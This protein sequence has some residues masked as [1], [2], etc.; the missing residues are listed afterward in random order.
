MSKWI[1]ETFEVE[2]PDYPYSTKFDRKLT[3]EWTYEGPDEIICFAWKD[4]D[5][6]DLSYGYHDVAEDEKDKKAQW[7]YLVLH[8]G[9]PMYPARITFDKDPL[10]LS[11]IRQGNGPDEEEYLSK[12]IKNQKVF[13]WDGEEEVYPINED[14]YVDRRYEDED[15]RKGIEIIKKKP[16]MYTT[17][18]PMLP[19]LLIET[20]Y[21]LY[22]K[23]K[24][25]VVKPYPKRKPQITTQEFLYVYYRMIDSINNFIDTKCSSMPPKK[26]EPYVKYRDELVALQEKAKFYWDKP[27]MITLPQDPRQPRD[28]NYKIETF[29]VYDGPGHKLEVTPEVLQEAADSVNMTIPPYLR[30]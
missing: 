1:K 17:T 29:Q 8:A 18:W 23:E 30:V 7:E 28:D 6:I 25:E 24:E 21:F 13:Y 9:I 4:N 12:Y 22:D 27:W 11:L 14:S 10:L 19:S 2:I 5:L 26:R 20:G 15:G 3:Q 16:W